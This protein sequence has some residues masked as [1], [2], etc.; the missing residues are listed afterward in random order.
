MPNSAVFRV[1]APVVNVE[2]GGASHNLTKLE[3]ASQ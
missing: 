3:I 1:W 2:V